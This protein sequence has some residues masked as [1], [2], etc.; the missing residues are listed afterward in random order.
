MYQSITYTTSILNISIVD[1]FI[2]GS[3][4]TY[5]TRG[6]VNLRSPDAVSGAGDVQWLVLF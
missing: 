5:V 6:L 2:H 1:F 3:M 4:K